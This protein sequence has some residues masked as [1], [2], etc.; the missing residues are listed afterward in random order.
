MESWNTTSVMFGPFDYI[1]NREKQYT[2]YCCV[3]GAWTNGSRVIARYFVE[4]LE[5]GI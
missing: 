3:Y 5:L 2:K 4:I 1:L